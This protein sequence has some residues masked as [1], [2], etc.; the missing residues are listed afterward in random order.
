[1]IQCESWLP[2]TSRSAL[3]AVLNSVQ[4]SR[5]SD[6]GQATYAPEVEERWGNTAAYAES[7][8]RVQSYGPDD[9]AK[10]KSEGRAIEAGLATLLADGSPPDSAE[11]TAL[12]RAHRE[13]I[14]R[15]FYPVS[16]SA[17]LGLADM[18]LADP[19]FAAHYEQI[20]PG[21]AQFVHDAIHASV[22]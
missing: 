12:A 10:I 15:W 7:N 8:R 4:M 14:T 2:P 1:M 22:N 19:R 9:W 16:E 20:A 13:H 21:L 11:A 6:F 3:S 5:V 18:Y 17:H